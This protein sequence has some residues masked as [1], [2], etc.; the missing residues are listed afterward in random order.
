MMSGSEPW[1]T[2]QC[3]VP[4]CIDTL[5][6]PGKEVYVAADHSGELLGFVVLTLQ[7]GF[8]GYIQ[9]LCVA[10][11]HRRQGVGRQLVAFAEERIFRVSPNVFICVSSFNAAA[12]G[13]YRR[14]GYAVAGELRDFIV[15]G[16]SE[17][18]LRKTIA[19]WRDFKK[20]P[21]GPDRSPRS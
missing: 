19:P 3:D 7:G 2:L 17:I 20:A 14:L 13:F 11:D 21:A 9:T 6:S 18:L 16:H 1:I 4:A 10:A 15:R 12:Q 8:I 5:T